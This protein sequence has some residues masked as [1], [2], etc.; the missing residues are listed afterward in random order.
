MIGIEEKWIAQKIKE[1]R[2]LAKLSQV[3]LEV[4]IGTSSGSISRMENG[5]TSPTKETLYKIA[6]VLNLNPEDTATLFGIKLNRI[7]VK[8]IDNYQELRE[9]YSINP[10]DL[11]LKV[12]PDEVLD[13]LEKELSSLGY[14]SPVVYLKNKKSAIFRLHKANISERAEFVAKQLLGK[15]IYD[16]EYSLGDKTLITQAILEGKIQ[17]SP[18]IFEILIPH[19][20]DIY[21]LQSKRGARLSIALPL[22]IGSKVIGCVSFLTEKD[23]MN[24]A[25][26]EKL[27]QLAENTSKG[28]YTAEL[29]KEVDNDLTDKLPDISNR[30]GEG[31]WVSI[32]DFL[33][34]G[35]VSNLLVY[36]RYMQIFSA[37]FIFY[38]F[39]WIFNQLFNQPGSFVYHL[40]GD[41]YVVMAVFAAY[42]GYISFKFV[43]KGKNKLGIMLFILML[44]AIGHIIGQIYNSMYYYVKGD[45]VYPSLAEFGFLT[46]TLLSLYLSYYIYCYLRKKSIKVRA[47]LFDFGIAGGI[48][49]IILKLALL[50]LDTYNW[51]IEGLKASIFDLAYVIGQ[52]LAVSISFLGLLKLRRTIVSKETR[53]FFVLYFLSSIILYISDAVFTYR[54]YLDLYTGGDLADLLYFLYYSLIAFGHVAL[55][56][57]IK[58]DIDIQ[59]RGDEIKDYRFEIDKVVKKMVG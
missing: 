2:H 4:E 51:T 32:K 50:S 22:K 25:D 55:L 43:G 1:Y 18:D 28:I 56:A 46:S 37:I 7:P 12:N 47:G 31:I 33:R 3:A 26:L 52:S 11:I 8:T 19:I 5:K 45:V 41:I 35:S 48:L 38:I 44:I 30:N 6:R 21:A 29:R 49:L 53:F 15:D 34:Y 24:N 39:W 10:Y 36:E 20:G 27:N 40:W 58:K 54:Y 14:Q 59:N 13:Q 42:L 16:V 23:S 17:I 57:T 9:D